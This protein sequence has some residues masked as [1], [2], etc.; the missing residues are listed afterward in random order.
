MAFVDL[1]T[2]FEAKVDDAKNKETVM[3]LAESKFKSATDEFQV[4]L[5]EVEKL[6][7]DLTEAMQNV[8]P[9]TGKV[10]QF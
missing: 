1:M 4:S 9:A 5:A 7:S 3:N 8:F 2:K 6:R 10:R